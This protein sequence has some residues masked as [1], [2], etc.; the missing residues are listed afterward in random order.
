MQLERLWATHAKQ[1]VHAYGLRPW[2]KCVATISSSDGEGTVEVRVMP[3]RCAETA[4][5]R[6]EAE[7]SWQESYQAS[8]GYLAAA[9]DVRDRSYW[10]WA[11]PGYF[12]ICTTELI[13]YEWVIMFQ[14]QAR[15]ELR[16]PAVAAAVFHS[17]GCFE[18]SHVFLR[19]SRFC[20]WGLKRLNHDGEGPGESSG[21]WP[22]EIGPLE[23][24]TTYGSCKYAVRRTR[25]G[26]GWEVSMRTGRSDGVS[27]EFATL[28]S[29]GRRPERVH[30]CRAVGLIS[31]PELNGRECMV[32]SFHP[33]KGRYIVWFV[34]ST[35]PSAAPRL[36]SRKDPES[37]LIVH[38]GVIKVALK[39]QNVVLP[40]M[41]AV[42]ICGLTDAGDPG[43]AA[44][45]GRC[46]RIAPTRRFGELEPATCQFPEPVGVPQWDLTGAEEHSG[47]EVPDTLA[48]RLVEYPSGAT[49]FGDAEA[50]IVHI[51]LGKC[52]LQLMS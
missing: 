52:L 43:M 33:E 35:S 27:D 29:V 47:S 2:L 18:D 34:D 28:R 31:R 15:S 39:P 5:C 48:V 7:L 8:C 40:P 49:G 9:G 50:T 32:V 45:N 13:D 36:G 11:W 12:E 19:R 20:Q 30:G 41:A 10:G 25:G 4:L 42:K 38:S 23:L 17:D 3:W 21:S 6:I 22:Y 1:Y 14:A 26:G 16:A 44:L 51:P 46:G 24:E 37:Q